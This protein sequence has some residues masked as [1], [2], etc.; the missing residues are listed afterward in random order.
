MFRLSELK[1]A[2]T[3]WRKS[4]NTNKLRPNKCHSFSFM[5]ARHA[6]NSRLRCPRQGERRERQGKL[7][8]TSLAKGTAKRSQFVMHNWLLVFKEQRGIKAALSWKGRALSDSNSSLRTLRE[9]DCRVAWMGFCT[10]AKVSARQRYIVFLVFLSVTPPSTPTW[11]QV[12]PTLDASMIQFN[13][14]VVVSGVHEWAFKRRIS[15]TPSSQSEKQP[16][17]VSYQS[18]SHFIKGQSVRWIPPE[19]TH[20]VKLIC[21]ALL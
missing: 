21:R 13:L 15:P 16:M 2:D 17:W 11:S 1:K 12:L 9:S 5:F 19:G 7:L 8:C 10:C 18:S 3:R 6:G 20:Y 14:A 4:R